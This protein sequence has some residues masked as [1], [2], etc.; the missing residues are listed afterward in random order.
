MLINKGYYLIKL[1]RRELEIIINS[2]FKKARFYIC[3]EFKTYNDIRNLCIE[4]NSDKKFELN[5]FS[6]VVL[7]D[8]GYV[9]NPFPY[10]PE[11]LWSYS[12]DPEKI[13]DLVRPCFKE[14]LGK[15]LIRVFD[16]IT[17][18]D[19]NVILISLFKRS[20]SLV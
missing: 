11:F 18:S 4:Y 1:E 9:I 8:S 5:K 6:K 19:R 3:A 17:I 13:W 12:K 15:V 2:L 16:E 7:V 14:L 20:I 10:I